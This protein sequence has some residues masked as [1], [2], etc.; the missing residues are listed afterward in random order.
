MDQELP[1][2]PQEEVQAAPITRS[3]GLGG[4]LKPGAPCPPLPAQHAELPTFGVVPV[5]S[6]PN[7]GLALPERHP[8]QVVGPTADLNRLPGGVHQGP[9]RAFGVVVADVL[10]VPHLGG[11]GYQQGQARAPCRVSFQNSAVSASACAQPKHGGLQRTRGLEGTVQI[12]LTLSPLP[13]R[14]SSQ[15]RCL[16]PMLEY[17]TPTRGFWRSQGTDLFCHLLDL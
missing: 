13:S 5:D 11:E 3:S 4:A 2:R 12:S 14:A 15:I 10:S 6:F 1:T 7:Q 8:Q 17:A 16:L 9:R